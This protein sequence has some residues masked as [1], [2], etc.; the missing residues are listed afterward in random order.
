MLST[1]FSGFVIGAG[2]ICAIGAQS[3]YALVQAVRKNH[4][5]AIALTCSITDFVL[6]SLGVLG[7]GAL[8]A[9]NPLFGVIACLGGVIFL[10]IFGWLNLKKTLRNN[11]VELEVSGQKQS[12]K[13]TILVTL[14]ISLLN[15]HVYLDTVVMLG[16][17]STNYGNPGCYIFGLGSITASFV[18]FLTLAIAGKYLANLFKKPIT[19]RI[20]YGIVSIMVWVIAITL[21]RELINVQWPA[22]MASL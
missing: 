15:P 20:L 13:K 21:I 17:I 16:M 7:I 6:I 2:L 1:Y 4:A 9:Q 18:W 11:T 5:L 14:A 19:W 8:V 12:L 3:T 22:F 10:V